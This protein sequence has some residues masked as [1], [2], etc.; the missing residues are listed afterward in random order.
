MENLC[1]NLSSATREALNS[2]H[3]VLGK[4]TGGLGFALV[5][6][7]GVK[8]QVPSVAVTTE[9]PGEVPPQTQTESQPSTFSAIVT[10]VESQCQSVQSLAVASTQVESKSNSLGLTTTTTT[11]VESKSQSIPLADFFLTRWK[12]KVNP[13]HLL[14]L[15]YAWKGNANPDHCL[16]LILVMGKVKVN[17]CHWLR[18]LLARWIANLSHL[19]PLLHKWKEKVGL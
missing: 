5:F 19:L 16:Q 15:L 18:S 9:V 3:S 10:E 7:H 8:S 12:A 11:K 6:P 13:C 1:A 17:L 2:P 14:A 4:G